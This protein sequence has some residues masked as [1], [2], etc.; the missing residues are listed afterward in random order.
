MYSSACFDIIDCIEFI[1]GIYTDK[2]VLCAHE[3]ISIC[4]LS[5][6]FEGHICWHIYGQNMEFVVDTYMV[7]AWKIKVPVF[8]TCMCNNVGSICRLYY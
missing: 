5:V 1:Y 4:G 3:L 8:L 7:K 2:V 6:V